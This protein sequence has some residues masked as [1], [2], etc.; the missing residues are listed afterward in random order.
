MA[1]PPKTGVPHTTTAVRIPTRLYDRL[2]Q[3]GAKED[4]SI[5]WTV[6]RALEMFLATIEE[7]TMTNIPT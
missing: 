6:A 2:K 1:I 4:R 3:Y 5:S 7:G